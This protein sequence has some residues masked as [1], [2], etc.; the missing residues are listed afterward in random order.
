M[1][2]RAC[3]ELAKHWNPEIL[4]ITAENLK[5]MKFMEAVVKEVL[6]I[7]TPGAMVPHIAG[8]DFS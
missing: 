3:L 2:Y 5:E 4:S 6:T 8:E 7:R 1:F